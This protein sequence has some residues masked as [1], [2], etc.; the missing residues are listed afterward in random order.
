MESLDINKTEWQLV[1]EGMG[2]T[3]G[4]KKNML[5]MGDNNTF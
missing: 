4:C 1:E 3:D 5:F 2:S